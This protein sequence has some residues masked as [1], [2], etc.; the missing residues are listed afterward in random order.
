MRLRDVR[1]LAGKHPVD[2]R[3]ERFWFVFPR[4][5]SDGRP[6]FTSARREASLVVR[7]HDKEDNMTF[8]IPVA[9]FEK[10]R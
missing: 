10:P 5:T 6:L 3:Y 2:F 7:F 9:E 8:A 4:K 1:G